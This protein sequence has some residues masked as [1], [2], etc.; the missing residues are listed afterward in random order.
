[1]KYK[2]KYRILCNIDQKTN[3]YPRSENGNL[4]TDDLYI[5][6]SGGSQIYHYGHSTLVAYIPSLGRAHNQLIALAT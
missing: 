5:K 1:M 6:C 3:D 4:D 2:G